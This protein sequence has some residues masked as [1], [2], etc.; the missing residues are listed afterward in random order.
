MNKDIEKIRKYINFKEYEKAIIYLEKVIIEYVVNLI[1]YE[2][3]DFEYTTIFDL[4]DESNKYIKD[5]RKNIASQIR[6]YSEYLD[7]LDN[8]YRLLELCK[9]Y[10]IKIN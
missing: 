1:K 5:E 7:E 4:I 8:V 10:N 9:Y 3:E 2:R 6:N